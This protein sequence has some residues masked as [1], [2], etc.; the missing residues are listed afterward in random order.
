M[1]KRP[2]AAG[3]TLLLWMCVAIGDVSSECDA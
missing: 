1:K 2:V 3:A